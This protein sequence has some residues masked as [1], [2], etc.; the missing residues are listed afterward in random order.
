[1]NTTVTLTIENDRNSQTFEEWPVFLL[2][3]RN[4]RCSP[5]L[6]SPVLSPGFNFGVSSAGRFG[7]VEVSI[8]I[9]AQELPR[10]WLFGLGG[11]LFFF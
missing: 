10:Y 3:S 11:Y 9:E 6:L 8:R 2:V 7:V 4:C 1:M 5:V